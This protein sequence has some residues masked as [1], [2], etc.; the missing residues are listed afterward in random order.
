MYNLKS[1]IEERKW[2]FEIIPLFTAN[3]SQ[4]QGPF[5]SKI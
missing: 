2:N 4:D 3:K 1:R 5:T